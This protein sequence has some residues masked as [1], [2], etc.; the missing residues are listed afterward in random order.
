MSTLHWTGDPYLD[1]GLATLL[2]F[3]DKSDPAALTDADFD[4]VAQW[5]LDNYA[6]DPL[7]SFLTV[8]FTSNSW[9]AS[10]SMEESRRRER[11]HKHAYAWRAPSL[12]DLR[13]VF[14]GLPA[15]DDV[16]SDRLTKGRAARVQ[17]PL[18]QGDEN[19]NF[20]PGGVPGLPISG[21]ALL[22][23]QILPLGC[24]KVAGRLLL[25]HASLPEVTLGFARAFLAE[26]RRNVQLAQ[27]ANEKKLAESRAS[28]GTL[29]V[30]TLVNLFDE[31]S[32]LTDPNAEPFSI[33]AYHLSNAGQG[34]GIDVYHLPLGVTGFIRR[35]LAARFR[36]VWSQVVR[37]AR[38][39]AE[40][41][42]AARKGK[43]TPTPE[44][45]PF[46]EDLL[47]L[48]EEA[49]RFLRRYFLAPTIQRLSAAQTGD[50][51]EPAASLPVWGLVELFL[52]EVMNMD[53]IRIQHIRELADRLANYIKGE[54]DRRLFQTLYAATRY[55]DV[56]S[57]LIKANLAAL[58]QGYPPLITFE[59]FIVVYEI[60]EEV[61]LQDWR[62]A[63]DL[64]LL[65]LMEQL[66]DW[67]RADRE[68]L[69][70]VAVESLDLF[71]GAADQNQP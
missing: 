56:R 63:H 1:V 29:L 5:I 53:K 59:Q 36:P 11:G 13:C 38:R 46:Y 33:T 60:G 18:V 17:I 2:A 12:P 26:N 37:A 48:P 16:L 22:C 40:A 58:R 52:H 27:Q 51:G 41:N 14:T 50:S 28:L 24:A 10:A 21:Q 62:L 39:R 61:P 4:A 45:N 44:R 66:A 32:Y 43:S 67:L 64:M 3:S 49:R 42:A 23:L 19:I 9:F 7:K 70:A 57:A 25:V 55:T 8:A 31:A 30:E 15:L 69:E 47:R 54:N 68:L 20:Y 71:E 34:P 35:A 65:R 6:R